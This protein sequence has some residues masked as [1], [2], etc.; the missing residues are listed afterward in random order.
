MN[1]VEEMALSV[2][3][4]RARRGLTDQDWQDSNTTTTLSAWATLTEAPPAWREFRLPFDGGELVV[5]IGDDPPAWVEP[6]VRSLRELLCLGPDWDTNGASPIDPKCVEAAFE[7]AFDALRDD[8]PVPSVVPT[9]RGGLQF[10]WHLGGVDLE[11]EFL[12]ATRVLGLFEDQVTG[13]CWEKDLT[14]N[15]Q[16]LVEAISALARRR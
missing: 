16:P 6:T 1:G 8:T 5:E 13:E 2:V 12:S 15:R 4:P 7:L 3:E 9:S 10:E 11:I 14:S